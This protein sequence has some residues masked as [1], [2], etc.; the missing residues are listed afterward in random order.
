LIDIAG[1]VR[2]VEVEAE[3]VVGEPPRS[4]DRLAAPDLAARKLSP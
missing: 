1:Q 4:D 3:D 2:V